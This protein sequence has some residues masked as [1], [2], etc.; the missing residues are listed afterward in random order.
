MD[1]KRDSLL[2]FHL[3]ALTADSMA[4]L[5]A[6]SMVDCS[7]ASMDDLMVPMM[8]HHSADPMADLLACKKASSLVEPLENRSVFHL[9][10]R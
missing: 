10:Y 3:V 4:G 1:A 6:G 2:A 7:V 5:K 9:A 8:A